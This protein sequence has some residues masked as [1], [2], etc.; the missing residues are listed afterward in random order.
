MGTVRVRVRR[1]GRH[2][3]HVV[4]VLRQSHLEQEPTRL[5]TST[6][7]SVTDTSYDPVDWAVAQR[8]AAK[9]AG[10]DPFAKSYH[11]RS[12]IS[13][14]ERFTPQAESLVTAETGLVP[15]GAARSQV[16][17]RAGWVSANIRSFKRLLRPMT[18]RMSSQMTGPLA[19]VARRAAG[20]QMGTMLG[21]LSQRVLG[22]YDLLVAEDEDRQH[23]DVVSYVGPNILGLEKRYAFPPEEFRLWIA[24]HEVTHRAQFTGVEW[25]RPHFLG[26]MNRTLG[27]AEPDPKRFVVALQRT[28]AA[29]RAG[30]NPLMDGGLIALLADDDQREALD[31]MGGLMSLLEGHGDVTMDRAGKQLIPSAPRFSAVLSQRRNTSGRMAALLRQASGL[32]AK[33]RQYEEGEQFIHAVE[34]ERDSEFLK[35]AWRDAQRLPTLEEIRDPHRWVT[36][37]DG[38]VL[39]S[40]SALSLGAEGTVAGIGSKRRRRWFR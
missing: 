11:F 26:L 27:A 15:D 16:V 34:Q 32:E 3:R 7:T 13:D 9:L 22:Q 28:V 21:L 33:M 6:N 40:Q 2:H 24:L 1:G 18:E 20:V 36:R 29:V 10:S 12:V 25:M 37:I 5:S 17:D 38:L 4:R 23:Q 35:H 39:A 30:R 31:S 8:V 19:P 14:F